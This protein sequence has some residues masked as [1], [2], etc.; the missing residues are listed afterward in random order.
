MAVPRSEAAYLEKPHEHIREAG[1]VEHE[2][3]CSVALR[4][5]EVELQ[6]SRFGHGRGEVRA[7]IYGFAVKKLVSEGE[8]VAF[9]GK[10]P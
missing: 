8:P 6:V 4:R 7:E 5:H 10:V 2:V 9:L 3:V 1:V